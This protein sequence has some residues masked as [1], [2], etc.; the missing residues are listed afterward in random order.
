MDYLRLGKNIRAAR[1]ASS[2]TQEKLA[3]L[4]D[5][6]TVFISQIENASR[7]PSLETIYKISCSL[8]TPIDDLV[9]MHDKEPVSDTLEID[10]MLETR[11]QSEIR[12]VTAVVRTM[13][14][15]LDEG[16]IRI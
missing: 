13:L 15:N 5:L 4:V 16:Q 11:S 12:Y 6:S 7:K 10:Y 2:I 8:N 14:D 1:K 3:E 9:N